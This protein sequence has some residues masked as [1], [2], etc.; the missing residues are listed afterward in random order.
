MSS[1]PFEISGKDTNFVFFEGEYHLPLFRH[2]PEEFISSDKVKNGYIKAENVL[3]LVSDKRKIFISPVGAFF[4]LLN[5]TVAPLMQQLEADSDVEVV[6]DISK[7]GS[8]SFTTNQTEFTEESYTGFFIK[9]LRD[10][11]ITVNLIN[12]FY[13]DAIN[14]NNFYVTDGKFSVGETYSTM[15]K[16]FSEY[17]DNLGSPPYRKTYLSRRRTALTVKTLKD[18]KNNELVYDD[19]RVDNEELLESYFQSLGF[20]IVCSEDFG[21]FLEQLEYFYSVK[22]LVS[23]TG[24]GLS[25]SMFM[26][27]S[28]NVVELVT[29]LSINFDDDNNPYGSIFIKDLHHFYSTMAFKKGHKYIALSNQHKKSSEIINQIQNDPSLRYFLSSM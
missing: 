22:T 21:S 26:Q 4:H 19:S 25:N 20:E 27:P 17:L 5:D 7:I 3:S 8:P 10:R 12:K 16:M 11:G 18:S 6:I 23:L 24:S 2:L 15:F 14:I 29:P 28:G 9:I 13:Y 1:T